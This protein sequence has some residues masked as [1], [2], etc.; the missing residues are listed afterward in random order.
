MGY[1]LLLSCVVIV[2]VRVGVVGCE[3]NWFFL[4]LGCCLVF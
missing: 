1:V 2:L 4:V 3:V